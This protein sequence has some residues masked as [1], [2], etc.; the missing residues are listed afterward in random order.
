MIFNSLLAYAAFP[1]V[2]KCSNLIELR[3]KPLPLEIARISFSSLLAWSRFW[4]CKVTTVFGSFQ[5]ISSF[6]LQKLWTRKLI[7]DKTKKPLQILSKRWWFIR[8]CTYFFEHRGAGM[9]NWWVKMSKRII[10]PLYVT[11]PS[12]WGWHQTSWWNSGWSI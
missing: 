4:R 3:S 1:F 10:L 11:K 5:T 6:F 2:G 7:L 9:Y 12:G 8:R